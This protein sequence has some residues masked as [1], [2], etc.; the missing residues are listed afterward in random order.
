MKWRRVSGFAGPTYFSED[1]HWTILTVKSG[2][3]R[4][5]REQQP[6][7]EFSGGSKGDADEEAYW[8]RMYAEHHPDPAPLTAVLPTKEG[9]PN[10][11]A[12]WCRCVVT[13]AGR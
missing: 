1:G 11:G 13:A 7:G 12:P 10:W 3:H 4:L 9:H 5:C 6:V 8:R 2:E